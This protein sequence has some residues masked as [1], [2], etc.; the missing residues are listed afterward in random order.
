MNILTDPIFLIGDYPD[1]I[2]NRFS[3]G[4]PFVIYDYM[5]IKTRSFKWKLK[6]YQ[7]PFNKFRQ[8]K[9]LTGHYQKAE[10]YAI[11]T[12]G[13]FKLVMNSKL[14]NVIKKLEKAGKIK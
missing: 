2:L 1:D 5:G 9:Y 8:Y 11:N 10:W 7:M 14:L 3:G 6:W 4:I 12:D 13:N